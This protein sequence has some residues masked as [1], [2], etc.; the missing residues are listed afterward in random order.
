MPG[1]T[2]HICSVSETIA[3][4]PVAAQRKAFFRNGTE[5]DPSAADPTP[6][7]WRDACNNS[8][9]HKKHIPDLLWPTICEG[10]KPIHGKDRKSSLCLGDPR[11]EMKVTHYK[12]THVHPKLASSVWAP[13]NKIKDHAFNLC[14]MTVDEREH[15]YE[16][17]LNKVGETKLQHIEDNLRLRFAAKL[18]TAG[19][20]NG[21]RLLK[22]FQNFDIYK[23][24]AVEI[25]EF[26]KA[27][28]SF[29][30]QLPEEAEIAMFAKFDVDRNGTLDYKEFVAH[31]VEGE[32]LDLGF[33]AV[34]SRDER[35]LANTE[36]LTHTAEIMGQKLKERF[37]QITSQTTTQMFMDTFLRLDQEKTGKVDKELFAQ[38]MQEL[39]LTFSPSELE[40]IYSCYDSEEQGLSYAAFAHDFCPNFHDSV[41]DPR[42]NPLT[43]YFVE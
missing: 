27:M 20:N 4:T 9:L 29:G 23:T 13:T 3:A 14:A 28:N 39:N 34:A 16:K 5:M 24:G 8:Q 10:T 36:R 6:Q 26:R 12:D 31:F 22:L 32:Y 21:F 11:F 41:M 33:S 2:G 42:R 40:Y 38:G 25:H 17:M 37:M 7:P 43:R 35:Q 30:L 18:N 1:Y 15:I 19:N